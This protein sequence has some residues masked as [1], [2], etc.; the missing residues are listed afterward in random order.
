MTQY[1]NIKG[2]EVPLYPLRYVRSIFGCTR[3]GILR[4]E[5]RGHLP[6]VNFKSP[7]GTRLYSIEDLGFIEYVYREVFP[8]RQGVKVPEWVKSL[9]AEG[10]AQTRR[11]VLQYGKS[12]SS[13]DWA[14]LHKNYN[15]FNKYR[16][17]IYVESW[18]S[19]LL[20]DNK[21]FLELV[22]DDEI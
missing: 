10:L 1:F 22:D 11:V 2:N 3:E 7:K 20:D 5:E 9:I 4:K 21:F 17:Q 14:E 8:Y 16:M 19:R 12:Q 18:R 15:Q 6:P 13:E